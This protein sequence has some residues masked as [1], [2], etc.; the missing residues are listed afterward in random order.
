MLAHGV[1]AAFLKIGA[2]LRIQPELRPEWRKRK[3]REYIV[4]VSHASAETNAAHAR[5]RRD[6]AAQLLTCR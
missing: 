5:C 2:I 4:E 1:D 3:L 6:S